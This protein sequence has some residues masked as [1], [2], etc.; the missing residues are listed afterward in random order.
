[1]I[2][3]HWEKM[4]WMGHV[5]E[6][7]HIDVKNTGGF[8]SDCT[9]R[10]YAI[11]HYINRFNTLPTSINSF[12]LF[13]RYKPDIRKDVTFDYFKPYDKITV[14][15]IPH[16]IYL[17]YTSQYV[18]YRTIDYTKTSPL[19]EKYFTLADGIFKKYRELEESYS[20][21][22]DNTCVLLY[23]GNDKSKESKLCGY[24]EMIKIAENIRKNHPEVKFLLQSDETEFLDITQQHF[25]DDC[26]YFTGKI[27]H[28]NR[29][30]D[31]V[32]NVYDNSDMFSQYYL[33]IT[34]LMSKC[35]YVICQSGNT[36]LWV[37][38]YRGNCSGVHQYTRRGKWLHHQ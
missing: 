33:A 9:S 12:E 11:C 3:D 22:Y 15:T 24:S 34:Y 2:D 35:K 17:T 4:N 19:I 5:V 7:D 28:M 27:R 18:N 23:R 6:R 10:L 32:D 36:S 14:N 38:L 31:T 21:D 29:Q 20:I 26:F 1:M 37:M 13:E 16:D 30:M 25:K 8:F